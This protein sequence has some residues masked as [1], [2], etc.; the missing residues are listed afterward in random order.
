M[1]VGLF[2]RYSNTFTGAIGLKLVD[3]QQFS[4]FSDNFGPLS[5]TGMGYHLM[6]YD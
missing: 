6:F 4:G 1:Q 2:C 5:W 3:G